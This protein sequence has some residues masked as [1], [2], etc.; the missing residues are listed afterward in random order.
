MTATTMKSS[1]LRVGEKIKQTL[2][3]NYREAAKKHPPKTPA[4]QEQL[5]VGIV[6]ALD[7]MGRLGLST[8]ADADRLQGIINYMTR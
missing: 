8:P 3:R 7:P 4:Q 5:A 6:A 1:D 2:R